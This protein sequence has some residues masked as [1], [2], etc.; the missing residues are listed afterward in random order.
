MNLRTTPL[1]L[2]FFSFSLVLSSGLE[3]RSESCDS[4]QSLS[5]ENTTITLAQSVAAGEFI[6]PGA[7]QQERAFKETPAFCRVAATLKTS[8]D[9]DIKIEVW[10]PIYGWNGKFMGIGNGG[11]SGAVSYAQMTPALRRGYAASST[12]TGHTS[13]GGDASWALGHPEKQIDFGYRA[14]HEMT[15]RAKAIV[16]AFYSNPPQYSYWDGCSSGGKQGLKEAQDFPNDYDGIIA[17]APANNWTHL[18]AQILSVAQAVRKD[19]AS[20]I[21]QSKYALIHNAVLEQCDVLDK[22]K[23]GLL[24]DPRQCKF[25]PAVLQCKAGDAATCLT[26][27]QV[28]ALK[29]VYEP[30]RNPRTGEEIYPGLSV[31][32]EL[33]WGVLPQPFA[34]AE[35][36]FKYI[37]AQNPN[38]DFR[39]FDL[40]RDVAKADAIDADVG[41]FRAINPDLTAFKNRGGKLIQYHGWNDQQIAAQNSINYYENVV[42]RFGNSKQVDDFYRLFMVPGMMHCQGGAGAPDRFDRVSA[43]ENWVEKGNA[44]EEILGSHF[45]N[46]VVDRTRP[47]CP[48]PKV[49]QWNGSG[50]IDDAVNFQCVSPNNR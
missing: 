16:A 5:L 45:T 3:A 40:D 27:P 22:A 28:T 38:W 26:S 31:G 13:G 24:E 15:V 35:T 18:M 8:S 32:S 21:P 2:V 39:T 48:Y 37:V 42:K 17:G 36:H 9:S 47:L 25:D 44:P 49:A 41:H 23:D 50:T 30:A 29:H 4:L 43:L 33:G 7:Q 14:V 10:M 20:A 46:G 11:F 19:E 1:V 34:V 12:D 6:P